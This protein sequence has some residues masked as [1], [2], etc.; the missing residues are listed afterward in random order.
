MLIAFVGAFRGFQDMSRLRT[1]TSSP[2]Q[3]RRG[4]PLGERGESKIYGSLVRW[5]APHTKWHVGSVRSP[6]WS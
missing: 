1:A 5:R 4:R 3:G 6:S 2:V